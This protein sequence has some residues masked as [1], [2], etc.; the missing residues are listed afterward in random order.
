VRKAVFDCNI[1]AQA[2]MNP[3]GPAGACVQAAFDGA[4]ILY[5]ADFVFSEI[6]AIP[7][8]P[9]PSRAGVTPQMAQKLIELLLIKAEFLSVFATLYV[10]PIDEDDSSYVNLA[11]AAGAEFI[12]SR[13]RH[14]LNLGNPDKPWSA[15]FR[16]RFPN[17]RVIAPE[18]LLRVVRQD[19]QR[20]S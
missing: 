9:T 20:Q 19:Q 17:M 16:A 15:E 5:V 1:F 12:V 10:H 3:I 13:D 8:K 7:G 2:M 4:V 6:R 11:L 18:E 14:L